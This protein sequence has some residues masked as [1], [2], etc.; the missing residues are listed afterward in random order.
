MS[1][2]DAIGRDQQERSENRERQLAKCGDYTDDDCPNC[3]RHRVMR[4]DDG[5]RRCEKCCWCIEDSDYDYEFVSYMNC[6]S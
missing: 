1:L 6:L 3:T 2:G 5:K 4:G